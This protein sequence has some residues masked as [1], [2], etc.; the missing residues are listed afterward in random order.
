MRTSKLLMSVVAICALAMALLMLWNEESFSCE[1]FWVKVFETMFIF[2]G[3][4]ASIEATK[5]KI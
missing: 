2:V 4:I 3:V 1:L 5:I